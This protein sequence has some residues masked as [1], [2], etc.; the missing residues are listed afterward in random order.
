MTQP[1]GGPDEDGVQRYPP[2]EDVQV[3]GIVGNKHQLPNK[4]IQEKCHKWNCKES[5]CEDDSD[6]RWCFTV[7]MIEYLLLQQPKVEEV[8]KHIDLEQYTER[9][10]DIHYKFV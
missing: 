10:A 1:V 4:S 3:E 2:S 9:Q 7:G 5:A 8:D 6:K